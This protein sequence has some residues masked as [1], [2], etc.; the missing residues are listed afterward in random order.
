MQTYLRALALDKCAD[1][2]L[3]ALKEFDNFFI[4]ENTMYALLKTGRYDECLK[5]A[6][7]VQD[8][9]NPVPLYYAAAATLESGEFDASAEYVLELAKQVKTS[10][11]PKKRTNYCIPTFLCWWWIPKPQKQ[12]T[13]F[14]AMS[15]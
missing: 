15:R 11:Y 10:E 7:E 9:T 3:E 8:D 5:L 13:A 4:R 14:S 2:G 12:N 6:K 1:Y